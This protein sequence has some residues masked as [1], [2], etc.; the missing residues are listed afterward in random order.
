[1]KHEPYLFKMCGQVGSQFDHQIP[2]DFQ[3]S[4]QEGLSPHLDGAEGLQQQL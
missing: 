3:L 2:P 4:E 1:M